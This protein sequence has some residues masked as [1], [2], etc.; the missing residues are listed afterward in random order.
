MLSVKG[1]LS[2]AR[3]RSCCSPADCGREADSVKLP[4]AGR[5]GGRLSSERLCSA[6]VAAVG[7]DF[8]VMRAPAASHSR[9]DN[10]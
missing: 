3:A 1:R 9:M 2:G 10:G 4:I 5:A 8:A 7:I 6:V